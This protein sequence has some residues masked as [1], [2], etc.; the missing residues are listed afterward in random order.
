[1]AVKRRDFLKLAGSL[2]A[3]A[4]YALYGGELGQLFG[5]AAD[6]SVHVIWL[7]GASDSGCTI[8]LLQGV[9]PDL[10]DAINNF[11]L[12]VD[13]NPTLMIPSGDAALAALTGAV[14]GVTP[15]DVLIVEGAVPTGDFCTVGE[16]DGQPVTFESWVK[17][18]AAKAKHIVAVGTCAA[19]GGI[20]AAMPNPTG[21]RPVS[22]VVPRRRVINIPGCPAHPDWVLLTLAT[23]LSGR[24]PSLD[25]HR[26]PKVFFH[27]D[28]H[29][30]CPLEHY[31]ERH[32]FAAAPGQPGC[33]YNLGCRGKMTDADCPTRY[34]N[35]KTSFCM[36]G[37]WQQGRQLYYAGAPCIGCTQ[38]GFPDPPFSPFY[39][40]AG[41]RDGN[42]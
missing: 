13:F 28:L 37:P 15:L 34:W 27:E 8:S 12:A 39:V 20:P 24:V 6:G 36:S 35:N 41:E 33:L 9:D 30:D 4:V 23:L 21:C 31:Y 29:D 14:S 16:L 3:G 7:Q 38:P 5:Q 2:G 17:N 18:L 32:Q 1:M 42:D 10:V 19:F 25:D 22:T 26:R 40:R 11:R